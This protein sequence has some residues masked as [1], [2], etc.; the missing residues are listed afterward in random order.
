MHSRNSSK[1]YL[2][3]SLLLLIIIALFRSESTSA[4]QVE[5]EGAIMIHVDEKGFDPKILHIEV[6]TEVIF[7]NA[8][9]EDHW[10]ASDDHPNHTLY[11]GTS[12]EEHCADDHSL[13]F[14]ACRPLKS[15]ETWSFIFE[16]VGSYKYHDHLWSQFE[17]QI[18]VGE[19]TNLFSRALN[20]FKNIINKI[21]GVFR[22][23]DI[24]DESGSEEIST[25]SYPDLKKKYEKMIIES[26]PRVA[27]ELLEKES[28]EDE[29]VLALC[30]DILHVIGHSAYQKYGSFKEAVKFQ[31]DFCNSGYIHGLFETYF[32][33]TANPLSGLNKECEAFGQGKRQYDLWQCY[34]GV[35]HGFMYFTGGDLDKSLEFCEDG[36]K[37]GE[38]IASC[39]NGVYME[40]FNLEALAK[41]KDFIDSKNPFFTC[42]DRDTAKIDCYLYI[43]TYLHQTLD[44][45]FTQI[46]KECSKAESGFENVCISGVGSEAIKRNMNNPEDV[47][48]LCMKAG[49]KIKEESCVSGL[50][51]MYMNQKGSYSSGVEL[52][53]I[54]PNNYRQICEQ[55]VTGRESFFK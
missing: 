8:G 28:S 48:E 7:E 38:A 27:I 47:F 4:H 51:S 33:T 15:G 2:V 21:T 25:T 22:K 13:S 31:K 16:E 30:H 35:G 49:S 23:D 41:E 55:T 10:P 17:G 24:H 44:T 52:C 50:V 54:T 19:K 3:A 12:I 9:L 14:D 18:F 26:D 34:H 5:K 29:A 42:S 32:S 39:Q 40:V 6:G 43:P 36:L 1:K 46:L 45:E 11:D 37:S 20:Y 53:K